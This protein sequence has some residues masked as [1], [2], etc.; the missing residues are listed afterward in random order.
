MSHAKAYRGWTLSSDYARCRRK[1]TLDY[2][3]AIRMPSGTEE[4]LVSE[5]FGLPIANRN[6]GEVR[7]HLPFVLSEQSQVLVL[8]RRFTGGGTPAMPVGIPFCKYNN[9]GPPTL[10][11][12]EH[13]WLKGAPRVIHP[14]NAPVLENIHLRLVRTRGGCRRRVTQEASDA[15]ENVSSSKN[16]R[17]T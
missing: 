10:L 6:S 2:S 7:P 4:Q 9:S 14:V 17:K 11:P 16:P 3:K 1:E 8:D 15:V 12:S 13:V 5:R